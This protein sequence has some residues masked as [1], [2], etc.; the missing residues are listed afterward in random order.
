MPNRL[1]LE[2]SSTSLYWCLATSLAR[3]HPLATGNTRGAAAA[4]TR[5]RPT[6]LRASMQRFGVA[7]A[8]TCLA[9]ASA[10]HPEET[11]HGSDGAR[12]KRGSADHHHSHEDAIGNRNVLPHFERRKGIPPGGSAP[13]AK[14]SSRRNYPFTEPVAENYYYYALPEISGRL[15]GL[16]GRPPLPLTYP[17]MFYPSPLWHDYFNVSIQRDSSANPARAG[18]AN[19][20]NPAAL[21]SCPFVMDAAGALSRGATQAGGSCADPGCL[22]ISFLGQNVTSVAKDTFKGMTRLENLDLGYNHGLVDL[23]VG[24]FDG[25]PRLKRLN[26][27]GH[28]LSVLRSG[29]FGPDSANLRLLDMPYRQFDYGECGNFRIEPEAFSHLRN[30]EVLNLHSNQIGDESMRPGLFRTCARL[31]R[32]DLSS[33]R[34]TEITDSTFAGLRGSLWSLGL[35]KN[36]IA[37]ISRN[38]FDGFADLFMVGLVGNSLT[39]LPRDVFRYNATSSRWPGTRQN[40]P[41]STDPRYPDRETYGHTPGTGYNYYPCRW[42]YDY[43]DYDQYGNSR[44]YYVC[45]IPPPDSATEG[46]FDHAAGWLRQSCRST[47]NSTGWYDYDC[48]TYFELPR[49]YEPHG[50][51]Y[52]GTWGAVDVSG[53]PMTC[54]PN[55]PAVESGYGAGYSCA[56]YSRNKGLYLNWF[57]PT[58]SSEIQSLPLCPFE[59]TP[60]PTPPA[61]SIMPPSPHLLCS[62]LQVSSPSLFLPPPRRPP[63]PVPP[64]AQIANNCCTPVP[65][66]RGC[67]PRRDRPSPDTLLS[68]LGSPAAPPLGLFI[69][70]RGRLRVASRARGGILGAQVA[71]GERGALQRLC[72]HRG[73]VVDAGPRRRQERRHA[74]VQD[75]GAR[76]IEG[77]GSPRCV[78]VLFGSCVPVGHRGV[79]H[80]SYVLRL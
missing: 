78:G 50:Y 47:W 38:A 66:P 61:I 48:R 7:L 63:N 26:L 58:G 33:N 75:R 65:I 6:L 79:C 49:I 68:M 8:L 28:R 53:N 25:A 19:C 46:F 13:P 41:S 64:F 10:L 24:A 23:A 43:D 4:F 27:K 56:G 57:D 77:G 59:V 74:L 60:S 29:T 39:V 5:V 14:D 3:D 1:F 31:N 30:L 70:R 72:M 32:I 22:Y 36:K 15:P 20:T 71:Q 11:G 34:L 12:A 67:T 76:V 21:S 51:F 16:N 73:Q 17:W 2:D 42:H 69:H 40:Y 35:N 18:A 55:L 80:R 45:D 62:L 37:R 54:L 44:D 9:L 52:K